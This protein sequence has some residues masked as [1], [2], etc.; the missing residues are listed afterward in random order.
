[1]T[2]LDRGQP[3][4]TMVAAEL[5]LADCGVRDGGVLMRSDQVILKGVRESPPGGSIHGGLLRTESALMRHALQISMMSSQ[6]A[7]PAVAPSSSLGSSSALASLSENEILASSPRA[8]AVRPLGATDA[9]LLQMRVAMQRGGRCGHHAL[10]NA[11]AAVQ[12]ATQPDE[13]P[14]HRPPHPRLCVPALHWLNGA[15][16]P[17]TLKNGASLAPSV[18]GARRAP[19]DTSALSLSC[20]QT[21]RA[22]RSATCS[23]TRPVLRLFPPHAPGSRAQGSSGVVDNMPFAWRGHTKRRTARAR[24]GPDLAVRLE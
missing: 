9:T 6:R 10:H 15:S 11:I 20:S 22:P 19:S 23:A 3:V 7:A 21:R 5:P 1:M 18:N 13:G 2:S 16:Q 17:C 12:A 8:E 14:W 24:P 4:L